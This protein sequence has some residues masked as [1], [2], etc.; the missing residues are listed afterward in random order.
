ML[1]PE[2]DL[3]SVVIPTRNR[4]ERLARAI[5][6]AKAQ[7]WTNIEIVVVDDAST[8]DTPAYLEQLA[9]ADHRVKGVRNERPLG[10]GGARNRGVAAANGTYIAFLDDDDI[11]LPEKLEAQLA[12]LQDSPRAAAVSCGFVAE[13]PIFGKRSVRVLP[14]RNEQQLL[15]SNHLGGASMCLTTKV[16]LEAIGGFDPALR[17]GQDWDLWIKLFDRGEIVVSE[18]AL[19]R[20]VPHNDVRITSNPKSAY[21]GRRKI[22][23]RYR[24]RM[25][26]VTRRF[27]FCELMYCRKVLL[28]EGG[29]AKVPGLISVIRAAIG[30][31]SLRYIFRFA[32]HLVLG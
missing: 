10:G 26:R 4:C 9:L 22:Y 21:T 2:N 29:L 7:T 3:V 20:Y 15:R 31:N 23:F 11:W 30:Q 17:S 1:H 8:D 5:E 6:S 18:Q 27:L 16:A 14:P 19:V 24:S 12:L 32:K 28:I 25:D 13:F